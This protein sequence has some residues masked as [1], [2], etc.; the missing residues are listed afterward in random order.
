MHGDC[1]L[2]I[3]APTRRPEVAHL[4]PEEK[5]K[6]VVDLVLAASN[7]GTQISS[8]LKE[9]Q[10]ETL[11]MYRTAMVSMG[12]SYPPAMLYKPCDCC[13]CVKD[14]Y[15]IH[16]HAYQAELLT[17]LEERDPARFRAV[18]CCNHIKVS[19]S[20]PVLYRSVISIECLEPRQISTQG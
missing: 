10:Q 13:C 14:L 6:R 5:A 9:L 4:H 20:P 16:V 3:W 17:R 11:Q 2:F 18:I 1:F 8:Q 7:N 19:R 15:H 12:T